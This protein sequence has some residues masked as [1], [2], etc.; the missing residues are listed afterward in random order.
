[1]TKLIAVFGF[2]LVLG[3]V[4][5]RLKLLKRRYLEPI[6]MGIMMFGIVALCQPV[7]LPLYSS[8]FAIL[9]CGTAGYI[10]VIHMRK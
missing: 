9:L 7:L 6:F 10:F 8:G 4:F 2:Y 1:M 3:L 5:W